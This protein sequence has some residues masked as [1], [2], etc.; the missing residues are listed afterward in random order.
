[1]KRYVIKMLTTI[2]LLIILINAPH[3][4]LAASTL[5]TN[6]TGESFYKTFNPNKKQSATEKMWSEPFINLITT[7]VNPILGI[8]QIIGGIIM[9]LSIAF[10][11][12]QNILSADIG[13]S[14]DFGMNVRP[15]NRARYLATIRL[16]MI[17]SIILFMSTTIVKIVFKFFL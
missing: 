14:S 12:F 6:I 7:I 9:V 17:G 10:Y 8:I 16:L 3:S 11:G 4:N 1:M 5:N 2:L 15:R 13:L